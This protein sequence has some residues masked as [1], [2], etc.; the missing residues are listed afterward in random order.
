MGSRKRRREGDGWDEGG[1]REER[2]KNEG[3]HLKR[4]TVRKKV[5]LHLHYHLADPLFQS[6]LQ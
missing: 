5:S 4:K 3:K 1:I 6:D 2:K